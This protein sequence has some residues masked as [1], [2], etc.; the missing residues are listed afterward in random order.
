MTE[1]AVRELRNRTSEVL[2]RVAAG[3]PVT[4]TSRGRPVAELIAVRSPRRRAISRTELIARLG[5]AQA[6]P[7]LRHELAMLAGETTDDLGLIR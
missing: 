5:T 1:V 6:D 3:E 2:E 4:I 7:A